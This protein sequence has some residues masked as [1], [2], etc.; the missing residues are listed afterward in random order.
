[1]SMERLTRAAR[2]AGFAM[3]LNDDGGPVAPH[4]PSTQTLV[5][6]PRPAAQTAL[7][8]GPTRPLTAASS[9]ATAFAGWSSPWRAWS[10]SVAQRA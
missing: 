10:T 9:M 4:V 1:M 2:A 8:V 3:A 5:T 6:A 7:V